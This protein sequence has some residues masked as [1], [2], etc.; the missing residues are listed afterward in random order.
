LKVG[1]GIEELQFEKIER[2]Q[3]CLA[4]Y[5][6]MAW[7]LFYLTM[8]GRACPDMPCERVLA[9]EEWK[10]VYTIINNKPAPTTPPRLE[11]AIK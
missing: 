5:M 7:R 4:V 2:Y 1:C 8:L 9:P 10:A 6:V 11:Q 3:R